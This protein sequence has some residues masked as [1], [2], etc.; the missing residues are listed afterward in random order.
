MMQSMR[1]NMK[2]VIWITAIVFMVGFG[3][4]QL[5]GVLNPP[6]TRSQN[7]VIASVNGHPIRYD[8]FM[9]VYNG[10]VAEVKQER[11]LQQGEDS[12]VREQAWQRLVQQ[13]LMEQEIER[14]RITVTPEEIKT[15][16]RLSPPQFLM[17]VQ[18]FQTNGKF[19]YQKYLA[20]LDNPNS[21]LPWSEVEAYIASV[22][23]TQKLQE[24]VVSTVKLS[25]GELRERFQFQNDTIDIQYM[26]FAPD[27]FPVDS[28]LVGPAD[29]ESYYK[30]HPDEFSGPEDVKLRAVLVP[31][32]PGPPDFSAA[33][34][35]L[36]GIL[37][38]IRV[39]PDSFPKYARTYSE[40]M[41]APQGGEA[42]SDPILEQMRPRI[43]EG[44]KN[45]MPG[46]VSGVIREERSVH[47]FRID[48]RYIDPKV[49]KEKIHYHELVLRVFPGPE[50]I[51]EARK[52]AVA[53]LKD[54]KRSGLS[55]AATRHGLA[56]S[57]HPYFAAGKSRND[58]LARFPEVEM[59]AFTAKRGSISKAIPTENGWYL[60]EI[61]DR[62]PAGV[63]PYDQVLGY[64]KTVTLRSL[65]TE[66]A[67][68]AAEQARAATLAG[69]KPEEAAKKFRG[70]A[71]TATAVN[72]SGYINPFG[73]DP[74][75]AGSLFALPEGAWSPVLSGT[76]GV[77]VAKVEKR[78]VPSD[79]TFKAGEAELRQTVLRQRRQEA[80]GVWIQNLRK[81][82][83]IEDFREDYFEV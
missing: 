32:L 58:V 68:A 23:P 2:L 4:L 20:E 77:I 74:A 5:G 56:A 47:I 69:M 11:E 78:N 57:E 30:G 24:E 60:F 63:K 21:Q 8:E 79:E 14:R 64:V 28:S 66:R 38:Q 81:R 52:N 54:A 72:R 36:Q 17:Q 76:V 73:T 37:D 43:R 41:S 6:R 10:L 49:N 16:I 83:K 34:T 15:A 39:Q 45:V 61:A 3:V 67:K 12:Y 35:R 31:R 55:D 29:I 22:L 51:Q 13:R 62:R 7:G 82:A 40:I 71:G 25:E 9:R 27:S 33:E 46:Q 53:L 42:P 18:G 48:K 50:A 80:F 70:K 75:V 44:L 26:Q 19:D 59:W 1:D 65:Q